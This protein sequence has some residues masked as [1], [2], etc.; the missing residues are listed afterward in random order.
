MKNKKSAALT[1]IGVLGMILLTITK[2]VP[3]SRI[4]GYSIRSQRISKSRA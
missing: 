2:V 4:A 3:S 1:L